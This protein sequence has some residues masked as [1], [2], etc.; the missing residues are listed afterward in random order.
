VA[1]FFER[2]TGSSNEALSA[3]ARHWRD[4]GDFQRAIAHL[5]RAAEQA[6]RG[7]AKNHA[8]LL[9]REAL[10]LVPEDDTEQR[11]A[12]R[13]RLALASTASFHLDDVRP[14]GSPPA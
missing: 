8:A 2:S 13:R 11:T 6:E 9:Y 14:A 7:W 10:Q 1:E 3:I 4:A 12:L 5:T